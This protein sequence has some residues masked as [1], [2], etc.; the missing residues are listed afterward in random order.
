MAFARSYNE[1]M[2][3]E[4][5]LGSVLGKVFGLRDKRPYHEPVESHGDD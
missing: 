4:A 3:G 2:R 5:G 1:W